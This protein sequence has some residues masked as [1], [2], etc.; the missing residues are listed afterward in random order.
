M[1]NELLKDGE[2]N[3]QLKSLVVSLFLA[4][5]NTMHDRDAVGNYSQFNAIPE[6]FERFSRIYLTNLD[7]L[8][9][10]NKN[11]IPLGILSKNKVLDLFGQSL[12]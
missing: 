2:G 8:V 6:L 11:R 1:D 5:W 10:H 12:Y 7:V 9:M 4:F 3:Q